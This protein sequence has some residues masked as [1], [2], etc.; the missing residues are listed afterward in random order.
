MIEVKC[1]L[2]N[3][4]NHRQR[5]GRV[6]DNE[7]LKILECQD[8]GL[9]FLS[10]LD[11][12]HETLYKDSGMHGETMPDISEWLDQS[13]PDDSRRYEY[14]KDSIANK[15]ILDFGCGAGGFLLL[16]KDRTLSATGLELEARLKKHFLASGLDVYSS[17]SQID[18]K[19]DMIFLFHVLEHLPDPIDTLSDLK[20]LLKP[21]GKIIIEVPHSEDALLTLYESAPFRN[22]TYWSK[23]LYLFNR[24]TLSELAKKSELT[25]HW[26]QYIQ[27]YPLS[28]HLYWLSK[29]KPGGHIHW[30]FLNDEQLNTAYEKQ[31]ASI[32]K[33]D[34]LLACFGDDSRIN[35]VE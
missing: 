19:F 11:H 31:L 9:V 7:E 15:A 22:F 5:P 2:C 14:F 26:I 8:C 24:H 25:V 12:I 6:R 32:G 1:Y 16:A 13:Y 33:T 17:L 21:N 28:N 10:D 35:N 30:N 29:Q 34:T 23:H 27:R 4:E 3:S 18:K 20:K